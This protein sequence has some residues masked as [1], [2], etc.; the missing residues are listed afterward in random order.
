MKTIE[1]ESIE[2][3]QGAA[4]DFLVALNGQKVVVFEGQMGAGKTTFIQALLRELG[5]EN[6]DG[7]PTYSIVNE[8][9]TNQHGK[10]FHLD[11]Y[12]LESVEEAVSIGIEEILEGEDYCFIEWGEKI[13]ALLPDE[14]AW[15]KV[16]VDDIGKR[17]IHII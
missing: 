12:R 17:L 10:V 5:I 2:Q 11:V 14:T 16:E 15:V 6:P 7:S 9:T 13:K 8:Y 1:I 4:K 3:L